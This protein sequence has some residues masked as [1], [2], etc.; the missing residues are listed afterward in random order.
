MTSIWKWEFGW[1]KQGGGRVGHIQWHFSTRQPCQHHMLGATTPMHPPETPWG[2]GGHLVVQGSKDAQK[3]QF[4]RGRLP[5]EVILQRRTSKEKHIAVW[6]LEVNYRIWVIWKRFSRMEFS[7]L[8]PLKSTDFSIF[9]S[10]SYRAGWD[11]F[12]LVVYLKLYHSS[13]IYY[14]TVFKTLGV[15]FWTILGDI[16]SVII[17]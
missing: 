8:V 1:V 3:I 12:K 15:I 4:S 13:V 14:A 9:R 6:S 5:T 17:L 16:V 11:S 7:G 10:D 2:S